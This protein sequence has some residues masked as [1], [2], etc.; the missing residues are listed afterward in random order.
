MSSQSN[1]WQTASSGRGGCRADLRRCSAGDQHSTSGSP[2]GYTPRS[3]ATRPAAEMTPLRLLMLAVL[4]VAIHGRRTDFPPH[5][6]AHAGRP[7]CHPPPG[8][9]N[10]APAGPLNALA[11]AA[12]CPP[13]GEGEGEGTG[14]A[15][16]GGEVNGTTAPSTTQVRPKLNCVM[17]FTSVKCHELV[18]GMGRRKRA[19]KRV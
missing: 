9:A 10:A 3:E 8:L 1:Q 5:R 12:G 2:R 15:T 16:G 13:G 19:E 4:A 11:H 18:F 6:P 14:E 17:T 7:P